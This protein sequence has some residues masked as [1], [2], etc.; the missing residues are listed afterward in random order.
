[1]ATRKRIPPIE[2]T[3][4]EMPETGV[5]LKDMPLSTAL[6]NTVM[7]NGHSIEIKPTKLK[8]QR[9]RTALFYKFMELYPL[10][11]V[12]AMPEGSFGDERDGDKCVLDFL[13]AVTDN[14]PYVIEYYDELTTEDIEKMLSIFRRVNRIDEKE[15]KQKKAEELR[16]A[17]V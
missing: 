14:N 1:M 8:Y 7:I 10:A 16:K 17:V 4:K 12:I 2:Q 13:I 6:E 15:E 5:K 3:V 9:N 11:E